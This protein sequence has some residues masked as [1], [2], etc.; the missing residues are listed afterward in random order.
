MPANRTGPDVV[1]LLNTTPDVVDLL[2]DVLEQ[3]GFIVVISY[4]HDIRDGKVDLE[5]FLRTHQPRVIVYDIA[6]PYDRNYAFLQHLRSTV[7]KGYT[8]VLTTPNIRQVERLVGRD[9][10]IYEVV[11]K[12]EDLD[13]IVRATKEAA[14][15]RATV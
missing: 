1:A 4:T 9:V 2:K 5:A 12:V 15:A 10:G 3:A 14:R 7:L 11:G 6:A 8:L 13:A